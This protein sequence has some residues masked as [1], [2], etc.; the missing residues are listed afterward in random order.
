MPL[1]G[2]IVLI[3]AIV[4]LAAAVRANRATS[5]I[6]ATVWTVAA[7]AA[8]VSAAV[9]AR[10]TYGYVALALTGCAGIAV[11]GARWPGAA[12]WNFV[13]AGLLVVVLFPLGEAF[14][15]GAPAHLSNVRAG[16]LIALLGA[17]VI[18]YLPTRMP[19]AAVLL[20]VGCGWELARLLNGWP[21][22][23]SSALLIGAAPW[24]GWLEQRFNPWLSR[25]GQ[26]PSR[27]DQLWLSF[28]D[29]YGLI[30]SERLREQF[31]RAAANA[32]LA[33]EL[34]WRGMRNAD[35]AEYEL[36]MALTRRFFDRLSPRQ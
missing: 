15:H 24:V 12:A 19:I 18:N 4:P 14:A 16:F 1:V 32:R 17:T 33:S 8:W 21:A 36:L 6:H 9:N 31:N 13:V 29:R 5:L 2:R 7:W 3:A 27:C 20:G 25:S 26:G 22:G 10:E 34:R 23:D 28:R 11:F 30:W 35:A